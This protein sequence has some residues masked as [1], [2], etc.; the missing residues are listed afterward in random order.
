MLGAMIWAVLAYFTNVRIQLR[1]LGSRRT[2]R[3][4]H[5]ARP[6]SDDGTFAGIIAA[7]MS[8]IGIVAAK[9][10]IVVIFIAAVIIE[11]A[12]EMEQRLPFDPVEMQRG[13]ACRGSWCCRT[14]KRPA[15]T[16]HSRRS[17]L[18]AL[19]AKSP[20]PKSP[21]SRRKKSKLDSKRLGEE[22]LDGDERRLAD[23]DD[24]V[25]D[26]EDDLR[27]TTSTDETDAFDEAAAAEEEVAFGSVVGS[28]FSPMDGLFILLAFFTA[29]K[30]GSGEMGD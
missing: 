22:Q 7:F 5:G 9:V 29:Y 13:I 2:G 12:N 14:S 3:P 26:E 17:A 19:Y 28:L 24:A 4:R 20:K 16:R 27:R 25:A 21:I 6:R 30:V 1:R 10:F 18:E 23:D 15:K 11:A 8:L